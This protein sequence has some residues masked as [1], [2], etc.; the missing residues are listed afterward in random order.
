M[1]KSEKETENGKSTTGVAA[2]V[3]GEEED[4]RCG[5]KSCKPSWL[6]TFNNPKAFLAWLCCLSFVQGESMKA[7]SYDIK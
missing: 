7:S 1:S 2:Q 4:L 5:I 3:D 6:Q